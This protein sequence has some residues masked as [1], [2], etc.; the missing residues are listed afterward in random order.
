MSLPPIEANHLLWRGG[1][2]QLPWVVGNRARHRLPLAEV[3]KDPHLTPCP[4][5]TTSMLLLSPH[6]RSA[7]TRRYHR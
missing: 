4:R 7:T 3:I 5:S 1:R 2:H 6:M